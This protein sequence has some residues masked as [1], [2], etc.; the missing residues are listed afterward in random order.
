MNTSFYNSILKLNSLIL[1]LSFILL[2]NPITKIIAQQ[3]LEEERAGNVAAKFFQ[4]NNLKSKDSGT[5]NPEAIQEKFFTGTTAGDYFGLAVSTAG[6]VNGDGYIDVI[7]G[8]YSNDAGGIDAGRAYIYYGGSSI[9][10]IADIILSGAFAGDWF[11]I[12]VSKAGDVNG[13]GYEDVIVGAPFNDAGGSNAGEAYIYFG[14]ATMNNIVDVT[15]IGAAAGDQ[16]GYSVSNAG[17]VN[18]DGYN[19]VIVGASN[20]DA[21]GSNAGR[22]YIYYGGSSMNSVADVTLTGS[23]SSDYYGRSVST[24]GDVNGDGYADVIISAFLNDFGGT[25]AGRAYIYFGGASMNNIADVTLTGAA[26]SDYFGYSVSTAGDVNGDGY[27]DV[28]VSA[29]KNDVGG[30]DAGRAY[31]YFGGASMN[32][33]AD[34]ILTGAAA[35]DYFGY[36]VSTAGDVNG[37]GYDDVI[38]GA[39]FNDTGGTDAGRAYIYFGG[40]NMDNIIDVMLTGVAANDNFGISVSTAG[41]VNGD[42]YADV[43]VGAPSNDAGGTDAGRAYLYTNSLTGT[44][45]PDEFFTG[46]AASDY[47]GFSVSTAG[48]V[49]GDG[50]ADVIVGAFLNDAGG[51]DAGRAY[52]YFGGNI[53]NNIADVT[54][55][56]AA[57]SDNFG[58]SVSTAGDVNG[59]G[60]ADVIVGAY[61]NDAVG[62][63]AGR[64][65]IYY[66]G[67]SMDNTADV[68]LTGAAASDYFGNSVSTAGD[69]NGDGYSDV[70][71]GAYSN[72]A[73]GNNAGQAYIYFGGATMNN[74]VDVTLT[75]A[76]AGDDFGYSTSTAGDVNGDGYADVIV[77]ALFNSAGGSFAGSAYIYFG[78]ASM[79]NSADV[80]LTGAAASDY[81]GNSVST[82]GDV[83]GD[84]YSDVIVG[85]KQND[86]GGYEAGSAYIYFGGSSMNNTADVTLIEP[87]A[88]GL[89]GVSVSTAG[90]VNG[91]GYSDVIVGAPNNDAGG[92]NAGRAY[93]YFGGVSMDNAEDITLTGATAGDGLGLSVSA[94]GDINGDGY[95]DVI[96]GAF[97][98]DAGGS[99]AGRAYLY[100]SSS[101]PIKPRIIS[102]KD[103][104]NDQGGKITIR[105][106]RSGNDVIGINKITAYDV[107]RSYPPVSG[108]FAWQTIVSINPTNEPQYSF[109]ADTPYDSALNTSGTFF[110]RITA[111]TSNVNE[112]WRSNIMSGH[113]VD[114]LSPIL[115]KNF[116]GFAQG[117][118]NKLTWKPNSESDLKNYY[119]YRS[120]TAPVN[121]DTMIAVIVTSDT[122]GLDISVPPGDSYYFIR[123]RDIHDNFGPLTQI[124]SPL[125][126]KQ[127]T[128]TALIEGFYDS[129]SNTMVEDT[130]TVLLKNASAPYITIDQSKVQLNTSGSGLVKFRQA[131]NGTNYYLV[132][133]HRNSIETWSKLGQQFTNSEM[134]Y[135]FTTASTQAYSDGVSSNL[136]MKQKNGKWCFWSGDVTHS[137]FIEY[138]DLI[139]VYNKYFLGLEVPGYYIEDVTG[140]GFVEY[141]DLLLVYNNYFYEIYSQ[142]PLNPVLSTRPIKVKEINNKINNQE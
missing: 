141:D 94:A 126:L 42:G 73:G 26:A 96:V 36:S 61:K 55:T 51:T 13:D 98:N 38:V 56:G 134:I 43:I 107:Q 136:P 19:D 44:D 7:V 28:I 63:E 58:Y 60:Y 32:N 27:A 69:V 97:G 11:G 109:D 100:L 65:Y 139:Q 39:H 3:I 1:F 95:N 120:L 66:G 57:A 119:I 115:V 4:E 46:A 131:L 113:S 72:D 15:L 106:V 59:D 37:D 45:I 102:V 83:N 22:A 89:F 17:D 91:D 140:N 117:I 6:D 81:F 78:G 2:I 29:Y 85:A 52:I 133:Q 86:A 130:V 103:V 12:S 124:A 112:Y 53:L 88:S 137:Y 10:N 35:S 49:N 20:N 104:P 23:A 67:S 74:I 8:A 125:P 128:F 90:D 48:D 135:N 127:I 25:D 84:G 33:I 80:T 71:V 121:P 5:N 50:F 21:G 122:T 93:I 14:G 68:T 18:G 9:D 138:D 54:L 76:A 40:L 92:S 77:G 118:N 47:F 16:F 111:R 116:N 79:N 101:P 142:N 129:G 110:F 62:I 123:A 70:I 64:A 99:D 82:A 75:G 87:V 34:V 105:W 132:V 114:N 31:I 30:T 24:A 41:D 108:N